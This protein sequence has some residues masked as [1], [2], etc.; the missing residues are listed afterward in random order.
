[1]VVVAVGNRGVRT[2]PTGGSRPDVA[3]ALHSSTASL[4]GFDGSG[5]VPGTDP[6]TVYDV[7][8]DHKLHLLAIAG[9][10]PATTVTAVRLPGGVTMRVGALGQGNVEA[11]RRR[12]RRGCRASAFRPA[13]RCR[14]SSWSRSMRQVPSVTTS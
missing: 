9:H 7:G 5:L 13:S 12:T 2:V 11:R 10:V 6:V 4:T 3:A 1:M 8:G 14:Q